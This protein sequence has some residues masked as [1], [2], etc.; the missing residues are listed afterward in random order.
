MD[1]GLR[2]EKLQR[3]I[4]TSTLHFSHLISYN[5]RETEHETESMNLI[6]D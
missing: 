2:L 6:R 5:I 3:L 4:H 1:H